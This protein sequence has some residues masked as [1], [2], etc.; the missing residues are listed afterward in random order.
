[1]SRRA[2]ALFVLMSVVWGIPYLLIKVAVRHLTPVGVVEGRTLIGAA[3]LLPLAARGGRLRPL[4]SVWKPLLAYCVCELAIPWVLLSNAERRIPS[5]L[6]GLLV[7]TV[8]LIS[9]VLA[10]VAG[11]RY[12]I[13]RRTVAGLFVGLGGVAVLLGLDVRRAELGSVGQVLIVSVGY[14]LGPMIANRWLNEQSSLS[15]SA[16]SL[17]VV[18]LAYLPVAI[19]QAPGRMPPATV[20]SSVVLLGVVCTALAFVAFFELIREV[21]PTRATLIT[22]FNPIVAVL[23]GVAILGEPFRLS[24]AGG[25]ALILAGSWLATR[26]RSVRDVVR[27]VNDGA[28]A[29]TVDTAPAAV[30]A[31]PAPRAP[32]EE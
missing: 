31:E 27:L 17:T 3:L 21:H 29:I 8:P 22:Y 7:A 19:L 10:Y 5:S 20:I 11:E 6:S 18:A 12:F 26:R 9:A 28:G 14:A 24:T 23:L 15:L 32:E 13:D 25:F 16:V 2:L 30:S 4:L 1:M